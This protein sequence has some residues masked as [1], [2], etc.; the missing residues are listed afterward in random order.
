MKGGFYLMTINDSCRFIYAN[1]ISDEFGVQLCSAIG[2][3]SRSGN[4]EV[5]NI[6]STQNSYNN[7]F[8]LHGVNYENP[9]SLDLIIYNIDGSYIDP[10]K[11]RSLKKWLMKDGYHW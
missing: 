2:N 6:I 8:N 10:N 1:Q 9:V 7:R 3:V 5:R 4:S 11:E